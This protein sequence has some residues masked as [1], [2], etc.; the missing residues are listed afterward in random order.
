MATL[1][2]ETQETAQTLLQDLSTLM[3]ASIQQESLQ[4]EMGEQMVTRPKAWL[5]QGEAPKGGSCTH[6]VHLLIL[7]PRA[8]RIGPFGHSAARLRLIVANPEWGV[9]V[10]SG[11]ILS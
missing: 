8:L 1:Q 9:L 11:G 6:R 10:D 4:E 3:D 5:G 7:L 2:F